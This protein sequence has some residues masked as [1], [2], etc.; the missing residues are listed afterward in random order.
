MCGVGVQEGQLTLRLLGM[1][2]DC[3]SSFPNMEPVIAPTFPHLITSTLN[4]LRDSEVGGARLHLRCIADVTTSLVAHALLLS[5][6]PVSPPAHV[7]VPVHS[8]PC[9]LPCNPG[10]LPAQWLR[11]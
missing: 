11:T 5:G 10:S 8:A 2:F 7:N 9:W 4:H 1:L 6:P 3:L